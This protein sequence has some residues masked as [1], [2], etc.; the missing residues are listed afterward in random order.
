MLLEIRKVS[1]YQ[2]TVDE[3]RSG[4]DRE[5]VKREGGGGGTLTK[6]DLGY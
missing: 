5:E 6:G 1:E 4:F 2:C 3:V